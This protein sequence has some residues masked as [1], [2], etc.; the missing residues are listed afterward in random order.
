MHPPA[1][2]FDEWAAEFI[3][4]LWETGEPKSQAN[5]AAAALQHFG[6]QCR[7][8]LTWTWRLVKAWNHAEP[9]VRATPMTAEI[10]LAFAGTALR[11]NRP[12]FA[13]LIMVGFALFLRTSE[14]LMLYA[15]VTLGSTK[16]IIFLSQSKGLKRSLLPLERLE[17]QEN[18]ALMALR[19]L[20]RLQ[21]KTELPFWSESRQSFMTLWHEI[22]KHLQLEAWNFKPTPFDEE[23]RLQRTAAELAL[24]S[25]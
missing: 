24:I 17:T 16:A 9:P 6:P 13:Y 14:M 23:E 19:K 15:H 11:W 7:Q 4:M 12:T 2:V 20:N 1:Q 8:H 5:Y 3:E 21:K 22:V 25:C 10:L 18:G